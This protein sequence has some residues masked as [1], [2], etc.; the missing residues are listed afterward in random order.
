MRRTVQPDYE[1]D[2]ERFSQ[3]LKKAKG[4]LSLNTYARKCGVSVS[5]LCKY[6]G[7]K[8]DKAPTP[9]T[10][11]RI[12]AF[13]EQYDV[14]FTDLLIAAGYD[15]SKCLDTTLPE[16]ASSQ[17]E[18]LAIATIT[19]SLTQRPFKWSVC[20]TPNVSFY[21][22]DIEIN[23]NYISH[24]LFD[25][26]SCVSSFKLSTLNNN[27]K[28]DNSFS[29]YKLQKLSNDIF[30]FLGQLTTTQYSKNTKFSFVTTSETFF[31]HL[32]DIHP[33]MITMYISV[34]LID[35]D[36]MEIIKEK[37]LDS[38]LE[39]TNELYSAYTLK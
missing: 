1:F 33:Y 8:F 25:F 2:K 38:S 39:L 34:I 24:W 27:R 9:K 19:N 29:E 23:D 10:L 14:S 35:L 12:S 20:P 4:S 22:L 21:D 36:N 15:T 18:K 3:L 6:L 11:K 37:Y 13:T 5:Y 7:G 28:N 32:I 30:Y 16:N 31:N 17:I 26:R